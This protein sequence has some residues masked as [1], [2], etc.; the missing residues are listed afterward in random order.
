MAQLIIGSFS[1]TCG[2]CNKNASPHE[3]AH[4]TLMGYSA[5][6]GDKGC[7]APFTSVTFEYCRAY[8]WTNLAPALTA[9]YLAQHP[10]AE[11]ATKT[12]RPDLLSDC[13]G[14]L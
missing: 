2:A 13:C 14:P 10:Q 1:S 9:D 6:P 11:C 8:I 3:S 5:L 12:L 4:D 7:G